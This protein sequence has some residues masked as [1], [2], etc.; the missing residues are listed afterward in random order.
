MSNRTIET[1]HLLRHQPFVRRVITRLLGV[2]PSVVVAIAVGRDGLT[3]MLVASQVML[4]V[5]LPF[6]IFPLV[7]LCADEKV[8]MV[9]NGGP[10]VETDGLGERQADR[11]TSEAALDSTTPAAPVELQ[12]QEESQSPSASPLISPPTHTPATSFPH[13]LRR[14]AVTMFRLVRHGKRSS[15]AACDNEGPKCRSF[16]S[17]WSTTAFGYALFA[18]VTVANAY[19]LLTLMMGKE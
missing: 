18:V 15:P 5:V 13:K 10:E 14:I 2:I 17:H 19:V 4:S 8:M 1:D 16:K 3:Q 6:V 12:T 9:R 11:M 7:W